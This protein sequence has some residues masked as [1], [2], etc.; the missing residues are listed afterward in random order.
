MSC[1]C[2]S[3]PLMPGMRTSVTRHAM[4]RRDTDC[5]KLPASLKVAAHQPAACQKVRGRLADGF[6]VIHDRDQRRIRH[7]DSRSEQSA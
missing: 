6:V 1:L 2:N 5:R 7:F 4:L 3:S